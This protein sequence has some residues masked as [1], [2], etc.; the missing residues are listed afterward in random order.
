MYTQRVISVTYPVQMRRMFLPAGEVY[1]WFQRNVRRPIHRK[2]V[3][4]A[5]RGRSGHLARSH[6]SRVQGTN[7][8]LLHVEVW[9]SAHYARSVHDGHASAIIEGRPWLWV[10]V[11]GPLLPDADGPVRMFE[12][13]GV[14]F[15]THPNAKGR[16]PWIAQ[17]MRWGL[18]RKRLL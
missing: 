18:A 15:S 11:Q 4:S 16:Q 5:P 12:V 7:Q 3:T 9:N 2:A 14:G 13:S 10:G 8:Y 1:S 6:A 17:A